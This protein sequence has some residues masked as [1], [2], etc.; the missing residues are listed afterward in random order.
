MSNA[1]MDF[2]CS[3]KAYVPYTHSYNFCMYVCLF[4]VLNLLSLVFMIQKFYVSK[5]SSKLIHFNKL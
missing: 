5:V 4:F 3:D 1:V 2:C